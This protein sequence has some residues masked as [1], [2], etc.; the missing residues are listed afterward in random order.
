VGAQENIDRLR[1]G[2][3]ALGRT[4]EWPGDGLLASDF[5]LHQDAV[6]DAAGAFRGPDAPAQL[7]GRMQQA[8]RDISFE[9]QSFVEAPNGEVMVV[10]RTRGHGKASGMA[11]DK[12]QAH[13]WTFADGRAIGMRI[14]GQRAEALKALGLADGH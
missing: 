14:Y 8:F 3:E 6:V 10:V 11:V 12:E 9:A 1:N 2:Y 4:G 5:E 7:I 13:V